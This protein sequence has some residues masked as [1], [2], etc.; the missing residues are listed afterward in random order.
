MDSIEVSLEHEGQQCGSRHGQ[1]PLEAWRMRGK[2]K[3]RGEQLSKCG[4]ISRSREQSETGTASS[5]AALLKR[6]EVRGKK[7]IDNCVQRISTHVKACWR[8][9]KVVEKKLD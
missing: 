3:R 8:C 2:L 4:L 6:S 9:S 5:R 7:K 1:P